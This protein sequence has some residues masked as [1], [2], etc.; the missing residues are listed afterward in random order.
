MR[1]AVISDMA[2]GSHKAYAINVAKTSGG[3]ARLGHDV[4]IFCRRTEPGWTHAQANEAY[5]EPLLQWR[6]YPGERQD[7]EHLA[8]KHYLDGISQWASEAIAGEHFDAVYARHCWGGVKCARAGV[9]T[10][11]ETHLDPVDDWL[12]GQTCVRMATEP[13]RGG[14]DALRGIVTISPALRER[15][16]ALGA[17]AS[18]IRIVPDAVDPKLF[19]P[20][21]E[22]IGPDPLGGPRPRVV[23]AGNLYPLNGVPTVLEAARVLPGVSFHLVGGPDDLVQQARNE[24]PANT[25]FHGRVPHRAVPSYLW[26]ADVL[27]LPLSDNHPA[28]LWASPMKLGEYMASRVPIV[29]SDLPALRALV[30]EPQIR[31]SVPD[32]AASL[33]QGIQ[34]CLADPQPAGRLAAVDAFVAKHTYEQRAGVILDL[35]NSQANLVGDAHKAR[36][37]NTVAA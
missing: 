5:D 24:A 7:E 21:A 2:P 13:A 4:V 30:S 20:P 1:I 31:W 27:L 6:S 26:H 14:V 17:D 23:F 37:H 22:G 12:G 36:T 29:C 18:R 8:H 25:V 9:P 10:V 28:R 19:T 3:L 33:A 16:V 35:L 34:A 11:V 15:Y 32:N